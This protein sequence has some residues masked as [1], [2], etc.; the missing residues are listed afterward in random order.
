MRRMQLWQL[1]GTV[2]RVWWCGSVGRV[3]LSGMRSTGEGQG[4]MPKDRQPGVLEDGPLLR[5]EKV[6][7][8]EEVTPD[9]PARG[10]RRMIE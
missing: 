3:L 10:P 9:R 6:R 4:R 1:R 5:A 7:L 2:R 8:Q